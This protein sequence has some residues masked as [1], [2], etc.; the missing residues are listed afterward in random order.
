VVLADAGY[1]HQVQIQALAGEGITVLIAPDA[2]KPPGTRP[3][4]NAG[5]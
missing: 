4:E 5:L 2:N 1:W 3:G